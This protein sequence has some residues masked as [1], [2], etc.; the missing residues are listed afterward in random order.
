VGVRLSP[1][2]QRNPPSRLIAGERSGTALQSENSLLKR[3]AAKFGCN[4]CNEALQ[5]ADE[6]IR[7]ARRLAAVAMSAILNGD[8]QRA[9]DVLRE[10]QG[11]SAQA[12]EARR[13][14]ECRVL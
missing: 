14:R 9:G 2:A 11:I 12:V 13:R 8:V 6:A 7:T 1:T 10:L 4:E 5:A 3:P